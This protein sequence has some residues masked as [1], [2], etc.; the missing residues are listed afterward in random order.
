M[1]KEIVDLNDGYSNPVIVVKSQ[2]THVTAV[3]A[4]YS[5]VHFSSGEN[6]VVK[7][8]VHELVSKIWLPNP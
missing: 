8:S 6:Q 1:I 7:G 3:D 4:N 2:I 5:R